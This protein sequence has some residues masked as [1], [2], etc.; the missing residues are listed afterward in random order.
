MLNCATSKLNEKCL[1]SHFAALRLFYGSTE[2]IGK[3][4]NNFREKGNLVDYNDTGAAKGKGLRRVKH[5]YTTMTQHVRL[6]NGERGTD[7]IQLQIHQLAT[8]TS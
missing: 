1:L 4:A 6:V 7:L 2:K 5:Q 8:S 3:F